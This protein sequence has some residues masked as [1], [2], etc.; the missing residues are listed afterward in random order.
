MPTEARAFRIWLA[1]SS[2]FWTSPTMRKVSV[3]TKRSRNCR[4]STVRSSF[5]IAIGMCLTSLSSAYPN[6]TISTSGGKSMKNNVIGS[7]RTGMNSFNRIAFKPRE[8][9]RFMGSRCARKQTRFAWKLPA[10]SSKLQRSTKLQAPNRRHS[11]LTCLEF[12]ASL[13]LG[14]WCLVLSPLR[15]FLLVVLTRMFRG[16]GYKDVLQRRS[17]LV[18]LWARKPDAAKFFVDLLAANA[19]VH[20]QMHGLP[21]HSRVQHALYFAHRAQRHGDVIAGDIEPPRPRRADFRHSFQIVGLA[22]DD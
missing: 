5:R 12:G 15:G 10:P 20:E 13:E 14:A 4:L 3:L 18:D 21:E 8:G 7:R 9:A 16:E 11:F 6:A 22:A 1:I 17:D 2:T 19:F